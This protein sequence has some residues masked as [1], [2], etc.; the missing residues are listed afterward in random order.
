MLR[1]TPA[2]PPP[3]LLVHHD[4]LELGLRVLFVGDAPGESVPTGPVTLE[5]HTRTD[6]SAAWQAHPNA[7]IF[8]VVSNLFDKEY[9]EAVGFP[10]PGIYPRAGM[11]LVF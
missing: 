9:Q 1:L 5:S 4:A 6:I 2:T 11:E 8:L 3:P 7:K 10:A